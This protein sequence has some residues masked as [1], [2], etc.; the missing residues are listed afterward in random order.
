MVSTRLFW[1]TFL[2]QLLFLPWAN[3]SFAELQHVWL[4]SLDNLDGIFLIV[5]SAWLY[6]QVVRH[7]RSEGGRSSLNSHKVNR[8]RT[9]RQRR[10]H[11]IESIA[12][13]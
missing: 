4:L 13:L 6:C 11:Q 1:T 5:L 3:P 7:F 10:E 2:F 8:V 12:Y 9:Y